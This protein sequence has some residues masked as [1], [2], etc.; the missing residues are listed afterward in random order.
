MI[1]TSQQSPD[2]E[3]FSGFDVLYDLIKNEVAGLRDR[4]LD[5]TSDNWEWSH[6]SIRMQLSHMASLIPRWIIV[7]LGHILYPD[8][9]HGYTE[10]NSIASS[11]Y[12]RRLDDE[13]YWEIQ[14]IMPALEKAINLVIDVLNK[15]SIEILQNN[16][17]KR[18]PSPQWELMS[19]AHY[20]GVTAVGNPAE[21]TM[22]I[23]ATIR[24]IYFEQTTHL[25]N[26]QRLKK[27]QGLSLI[28][29]VPKVGYWV[30][31]GWD[32]SQP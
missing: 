28:S 19:K 11:N 22:T 13:K 27:A 4:E 21:G 24:H 8:N 15:T 9:D 16:K 1:V 26:I 3:T 20:R 14:E 23:E 5:F 18:D 12:D 31:P 6:W 10:I 32:I 2:C 17:V 25:F 30:L 29:E 7:R